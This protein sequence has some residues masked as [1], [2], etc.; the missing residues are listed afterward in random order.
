[1]CGAAKTPI[2]GNICSGGAAEVFDPIAEREVCQTH[3]LASLSVYR[4]GLRSLILSDSTG[5]ARSTCVKPLAAKR[6]NPPLGQFSS[7]R[8]Q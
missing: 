6:I 3:G 4:G 7:M 2:G 1:M 8:Q 5:S